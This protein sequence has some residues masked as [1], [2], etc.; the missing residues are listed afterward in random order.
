M[1]S[2]WNEMVFGAAPPTITSY[3]AAVATET[4][5]K[6]AREVANIMWEVYGVASCPLERLEPDI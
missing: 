4:R 5:E 3:T 1:A 6:A 2:G